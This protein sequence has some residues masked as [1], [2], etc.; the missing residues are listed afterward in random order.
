M[1]KSDAG[2]QNTAQSTMKFHSAEQAQMIINY[3]NENDSQHTY[4]LVASEVK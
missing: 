1:T 4:I 3:W 2:Q